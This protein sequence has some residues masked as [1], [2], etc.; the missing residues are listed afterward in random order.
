MRRQ[1]EMEGSIWAESYR[2]AE[3]DQR[4]LQPPEANFSGY[5]W[6]GDGKMWV[7]WRGGVAV[8]KCRTR[9]W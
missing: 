6:D 1:V 8:R 4:V 2:L 5:S 7:E 3:E 9:G